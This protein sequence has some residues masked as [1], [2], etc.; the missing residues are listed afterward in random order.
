MRVSIGPTNIEE[1]SVRLYTMDVSW[2]AVFTGVRYDTSSAGYSEATKQGGGSRRSVAGSANIYKA[3]EKHD[4]IG[5]PFVTTY[6]EFRW[7]A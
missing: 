4:R 1:D 6:R 2:S 3:S 7:K 5:T